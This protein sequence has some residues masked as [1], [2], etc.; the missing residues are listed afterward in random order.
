MPS[1][2]FDIFQQ[3]QQQAG[4]RGATFA[5]RAI[6][7]SDTLESALSRFP[8][9]ETESGG[10]AMPGAKFGM[11]APLTGIS[12]GGAAITKRLT[13]NT[14][15]KAGIML[16]EWFGLQSKLSQMPRSHPLRAGLSRR[17]FDLG[18]E[19][20]KLTGSTLN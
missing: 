3:L 12:L 7:P 20:N 5:G 16:Q 18:E 19:I 17:T 1:P 6:G 11:Q 13:D 14:R 4:P 10:A 15:M 8:Q 2:L 9:G